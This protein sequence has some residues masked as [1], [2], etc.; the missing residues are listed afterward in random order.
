MTTIIIED[1]TLHLAHPDELNLIWLGQE[2]FPYRLR[3][4]TPYHHQCDGTR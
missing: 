4:K 3:P 1:T 2:E